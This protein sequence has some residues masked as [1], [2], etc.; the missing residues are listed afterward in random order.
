V[1]EAAAQIRPV[2][3]GTLGGN[4]SYAVAVNVSGQ[5]VGESDTADGSRHAFSWT[6]KGGMIDLG[7]LDNGYG[8]SQALAVNASGQVVGRS[9]TA[10]CASHAF[11][12]TSAG[13]LIDLGTLRWQLQRCPGGQCQ[14]T[15]RRLGLH[16]YRV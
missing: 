14:R 3:L 5:I 4:N 7:T 10:D 2:D 1:N 16:L 6:V 15:G 13:G 8:E 11:S 9:D 12:W